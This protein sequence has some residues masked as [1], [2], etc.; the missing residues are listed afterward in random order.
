MTRR[1][2]LFVALVCSF[3]CAPTPAATTNPLDRFD[4]LEDT[5]DNGLRVIYAPI[6]GG[7]PVAHVRVI[8]HVGSKDERPDRRGFAHLFEHMMFR[9][10]AHVAPLE[11]VHLISGVGGSYN[12]ETEQDTTTYWD[13]VP[14][15]QLELALYL[16][17][18]RMASF[19]VTPQIYEVERNVVLEGLGR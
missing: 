18:D 11:H 2:L 1:L 7:P 3:H 14:S 6:P 9:G 4:Y 5:L 12:G 10:S 8:Y 15:N 19:H 13:T 16:E 17:A